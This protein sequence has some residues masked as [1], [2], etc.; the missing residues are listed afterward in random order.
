[1]TS[2]A[3]STRCSALTV[4]PW[5]TRCWRTRLLHIINIKFSFQLQ[6]NKV[7]SVNLLQ[8]ISVW[9]LFGGRWVLLWVEKQSD[10]DAYFGAFVPKAKCLWMIQSNSAE[11]KHFHGERNEFSIPQ[12][13]FIWVNFSSG[14]KKCKKH[15][16]RRGLDILLNCRMECAP[17][18]R[19]THTHRQTGGRELTKLGIG[20]NV[21]GYAGGLDEWLV[22]KMK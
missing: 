22:I 6:P 7:R 10:S 5:V 13:K 11:F 19:G 3:L 2:T 15:M 9:R 17:R 18:S 8:T 4:L 20:N 12:I 1:M 14:C 21:Y 16:I